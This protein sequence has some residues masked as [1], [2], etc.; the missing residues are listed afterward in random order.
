MQMCH[1]EGQVHLSYM[2]GPKM[3]NSEISLVDTTNGFSVGQ[4]GTHNYIKFTNQELGFSLKST[5]QICE[6]SISST[7]ILILKNE[8]V[9]AISAEV[10]FNKPTR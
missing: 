10:A 2:F 8:N 7:C 9:Y 3:L 6:K 1:L 4:K 5:Q